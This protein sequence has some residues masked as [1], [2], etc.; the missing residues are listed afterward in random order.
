[1]KIEVF[2]NRERSEIIELDCNTDDLGISEKVLP[3]EST[4]H[5]TY[6]V[7]RSGELARVEGTAGLPVEL[8][9]SMCLEPYKREVSGEFLIVVRRLKKGEVRTRAQS[10]DDESDDEEFV[11]IAHDENMFDISGHV[12]DAILLA[13]PAKPLCRDE[14]RGL[15][16]VCGVN[17]NERDCGCA[18]GGADPRWSALRGL[19]GE[20]DG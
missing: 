6:T 1:M 20:S 2:G 4:V 12:H 15:C 16:P 14:C 8:E 5:V 7:R 3:S 13:L 19:L 10:E 9:C 18:S 17:R 11:F